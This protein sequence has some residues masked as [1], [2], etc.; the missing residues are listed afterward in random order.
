MTSEGWAES[1]YHADIK[2]LICVVFTGLRTLLRQRWVWFTVVAAL[3]SVLLGLYMSGYI[4]TLG[5]NLRYKYNLHHSK[6]LPPLR[7]NFVGRELELTEVEDLLDFSHQR[8]RIVN[9]YGPPGFGKSALAIHV[10]H[11]M[12]SQGSVVYYVN[13]DDVSNVQA[14]A[15]KILTSDVRI[16]SLRTISTA[17][18]ERWAREL[19]YQTVLILDNCDSML[20]TKGGG[21]NE[22]KT[23][24]KELK[25]LLESTSNLKI[26]MTS[27]KNVL[28]FELRL[29]KLQELTVESAC[30]LLQRE[31]DQLNLTTECATI[32]NLTGNVPLTLKVV[33]TLLSQLD[34]P[35][36]KT[37]IAELET[38]LMSTLSPEELPLGEQVN[39]SIAISYDY[40]NQQ[41][42]KVGRYLA[43]FPGSFSEKDS[44]EIFSRVFRNCDCSCTVQHLKDLVRRSLLEWNART[45]R[46]QLHQLIKGFFSTV[47]MSMGE[48]GQKE[49]KLFAH[50]FHQHYVQYLH[51]LAG[52]F[53]NDYLK[54][55]KVLDAERH[56]FQLL[57][58][59]FTSPTMCGR[60]RSECLLLFPAVKLALTEGL[61]QSRFT[62][63]ELY[64]PVSD[65]VVYLDRITSGTR[66]E[67]SEFASTHHLQM[68][69]F[70]IEILATFEDEQHG[71]E[72]AV[73]T[74]ELRRSNIEI[75][76]RIIPGKGAAVPYMSFYSALS[77]Y[78]HT[79][80][81]HARV[82]DCNIRIL[83]KTEELEDCD[84]ESC[85]YC[86]IGSA[87]FRINDYEKSAYFLKYCLDLRAMSAV[88]R[89]VFL[90]LLLHSYKRLDDPESVQATEREV[91]DIFPRL[92]EQSA[93]VF[94]R[95]PTNVYSVI[96]MYAGL[97]RWNEVIALIGKLL[98]ATKEIGREVS[99]SEIINAIEI[100][101]MLYNNDSYASAADIGEFALKSLQRIPEE[102]RNT[103]TSE[104]L[105]LTYL[106]GAA[107]Y[108]D[109]NYSEST[110]YLEAVVDFVYD[111]YTLNGTLP[112]D[113]TEIIIVSCV[114]QHF[115]KLKK[116]S[117]L[118]YAILKVVPVLYMRFVAQEALD[119]DPLIADH[120]ETGSIF[121]SSRVSFAT[122]LVVRHA[123]EVGF[124]LLS[125]QILDSIKLN[126]KNLSIEVIVILLLCCKSLLSYTFVR[127]CINFL[128][129][130]LKL[131]IPTMIIYFVIRTFARVSYK[132]YRFLYY[133]YYVIVCTILSKFVLDDRY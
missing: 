66:K 75:I 76:G 113:S 34:S 18:L 106:V 73:H 103:Y 16:V 108:H 9:I 58:R 33:G 47:Q 51:R 41:Q 25:K 126:L 88:K 99:I 92:M 69:V 71:I 38:R 91:I 26:L 68:Y 124:S 109:G 87:F 110:P 90:N 129:I 131:F 67:I 119:V 70:F 37:I 60:K 130:F 32:A 42:Q 19:H 49:T 3:L 94:Q 55:L 14:L 27:R 74:L 52:D 23:L 77:D 96:S 36:P 4:G 104:W 46:Y 81:D 35:D 79:L 53:S 54:V 12:V 45:D 82:K 102:R 65:I 98:M 11:R 128:W 22:K 101:E 5:E 20:Q 84:P 43:N 48:E 133:C 105:K 8:N 50:S 13:M 44:C 24:Q 97:G 56:N 112:G 114:T 116:C 93:V 17:R 64:R 6:S 2:P 59:N 39:A 31:V 122:N 28:Q 57:L 1:T 121:P 10:G 120:H 78:Y 132:C 40:L 117:K 30:D 83:Q 80:Q 115:K 7:A 29:Y 95:Y 100:I 86:D 89:G 62:A 61:L 15:E 118:L 123:P 127:H 107:K 111:Q 125:H 85:S 21:D 72:K 63:Q